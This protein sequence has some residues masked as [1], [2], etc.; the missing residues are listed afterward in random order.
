[1]KSIFLTQKEIHISR[2]YSDA[3]KAL[4]AKEYGLDAHAVY[5]KEAILAN[6]DAFRGVEFIFSTWVM[7]TFTEEEIDTYLPNLKVIFYGA[8]S[9]RAFAFPFIKKGVKVLSAWLANAV[10]VAEYTVSQ[11]I[12]ANKGFHL[13]M[14][15]FDS[16]ENHLPA[17]DFVNTFPGS[18]D[19]AVGLLGVG[20]IGSRV[21]ELLK[22]YRVRVYAYDPF[23]SDEKARAL[24]VEKASLAYIFENCQ[25]ISNHIANVPETVG[26]LNYDL[27]SRMKENATFINTGRGA[28]IVEAD[29]IRA[30]TEK[31]CRVAIL[32]VT[33]PEPPVENSPL[34]TLKNVFLTAHIAG[35]LGQECFRMGE[36]ITQEAMRFKRGETLRYEVSLK[37]LETMA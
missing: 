16:P 3:D 2:V 27:F 22:A 28:Q 15:L 36:Y 26:M 29:L 19:A 31:P 4:L 24:G 10:P 20:A 11:I 32:D 6:P 23:L 34:Y 17:Q 14:R 12:L 30:L 9:V 7:P 37:M 21:A 33:E 25:T 1:M 18:F 13:S 5:N 8:G 35:S